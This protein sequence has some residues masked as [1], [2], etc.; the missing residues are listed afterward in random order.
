[1]P[2]F[3]KEAI[4]WFVFLDTI[5]KH[6][7]VLVRGGYVERRGSKRTGSYFVKRCILLDKDAPS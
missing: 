1:M 3:L 5:D 6:I 4:P 2:R 7:R